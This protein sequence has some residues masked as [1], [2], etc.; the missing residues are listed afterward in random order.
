MAI[1]VAELK[2]KAR[3]DSAELEKVWL[4]AGNGD[5]EMGK[6]WESERDV[7]LD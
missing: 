1:A 7:S 4:G 3:R 6:V 5:G 2:K